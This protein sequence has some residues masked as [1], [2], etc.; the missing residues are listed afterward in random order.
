MRPGIDQ[1]RPVVDHRVA[2]VANAVFSR[3]LV[4]C[5]A[6]GRQHGSDP[7]LL[8]VAIRR[9]ALTNRILAKARPLIVR[10]AADD[11]TTDAAYDCSNRSSN[12]GTADSAGGGPS[13]RTRLSLNSYGEGKKS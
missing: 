8:L 3:H 2:V 7:D 10:E 13:G 9:P 6:A 12:N 1:H 5:D 11:C 4:V